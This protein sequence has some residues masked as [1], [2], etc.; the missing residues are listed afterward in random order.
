[1]HASCEGHLAS[2]R[3]LATSSISRFNGAWPGRLLGV[4]SHLQL[5]E[6]VHPGGPARE[7]SVERTLAGCAGEARELRRDVDRLPEVA[8]EAIAIPPVAGGRLRAR[9]RVRSLSVKRRHLAHVSRVLSRP[10][11]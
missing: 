11:A 1:M 8:H 3:Q 4:Q 10:R 6:V 9:E 2:S 7:K 5:L